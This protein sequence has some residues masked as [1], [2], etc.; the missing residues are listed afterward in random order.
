MSKILSQLLTYPFEKE[1]LILPDRD[2]VSLVW[3][4]CYTQ[5]LASMT[6]LD[7]VQNFKP[8]A[9]ELSLKNIQIKSYSSDDK[10]YNNAFCVIPKQKEESLFVLSS[11][12]NSLE[13]NGLLVASAANDA[14]AK[15]LDKWFKELGLHPHNLSKSKCRVVW[16]QK[17]N[18]NPGK[19]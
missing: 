4:A 5:D 8:Y 18:I 15:R 10:K 11:C 2:C 19:S 14:G 16:A 3:G 17:K 13:N 7:W 12:L 6:N 9:D 1:Q